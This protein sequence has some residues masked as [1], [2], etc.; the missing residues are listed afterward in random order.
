MPACGNRCDELAL[1]V[2]MFSR[3]GYRGLIACIPPIM[4]PCNI[5]CGGTL[6]VTI[7]AIVKTVFGVSWNTERGAKAIA[8]YICAAAK[9]AR[10]KFD[11]TH[12]PDFR[13]ALPMQRTANY[14]EV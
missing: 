7:L 4:R 6:G 14:R 2:G 3:N 12:V 11:V 13:N 10:I 5:G 1:L 8:L 9:W